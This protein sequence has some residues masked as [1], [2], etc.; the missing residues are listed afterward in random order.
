MQIDISNY[1][2]EYE[3]KEIVRDEVR[4]AVRDKI[5]TDLERLTSNATY[6]VVSEI[7]REMW[8]EYPSLEKKLREGVEGQVEDLGTIKFNLFRKADNFNRAR[9]AEDGIGLQILNEAVRDNEATIRAKVKDT[10]S[11]LG[12]DD[13]KSLVM[14][15]VSIFWDEQ[16]QS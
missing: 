5:W 4:G 2:T 12:H 1:L 10:V 14:E 15:A 11:G 13:V 9:G 16:N 6:S 8:E 7:I 3:M